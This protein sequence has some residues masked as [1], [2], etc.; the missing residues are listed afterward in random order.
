M[1]PLKGHGQRIRCLAFS[2]D[3]TQLASSANR[4]HTIRL[5][6]VGAGRVSACLSGHRSEILGLAFAPQGSLL[7]SVARY[8][9]ALLWPTSP[10]T[11]AAPRRLT[12]LPLLLG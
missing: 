9:E 2:P 7:G 6:D 1:L 10:G 4:G 8:G 12:S 11:S 3:G 5:W